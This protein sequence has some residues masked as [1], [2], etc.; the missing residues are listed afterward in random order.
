MTATT[1]I[2]QSGSRSIPNVAIETR[3]LVDLIK[4]KP[5]GT[6]VTYADMEAAIGR[7][8]RPGKIGYSYL[9]SAKRILRRDHGVVIDAERKVGVRV[10]TDAEKIAV[11][12]RY[13]KRSRSAV[14]TSSKTLEAVD[15][16]RL[17]PAEK[18]G[19][20]AR[21]SRVAVIDLFTKP[22]A[23]QR[24]EERVSTQALPSA[25]TL[26]LFRK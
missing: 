20:L 14:K 7:S 26:E 18:R 12:D 5:P 4:A 8:V 23:V 2:D 6:T 17:S 10:C 16:E 9:L 3:T 19:F 1:T 24:I 21:Q 25:E 22:S 15:Y 11:S 13:V